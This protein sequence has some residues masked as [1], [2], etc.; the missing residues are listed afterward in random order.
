[1]AVTLGAKIIEKHFIIDK[2]IGGP[3]SSF[4]LDQ[5][6]FASMVEAIRRTEKMLGNVSYKLSNQQKLSKQFSRSLYITK[7]IKKGEK[8]TD[9]N[10][11]S[12]R[13]GYGLHPKELNNILGKRSIKDLK[14]GERFK[15]KYVK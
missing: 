12:I 7:H 15:L 9:I 2:S 6:E 8:F 5:S 4:S 3:D 13:P 14:K 11:R 10:I 1:M